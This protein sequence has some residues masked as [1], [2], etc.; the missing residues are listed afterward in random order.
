M[1]HRRSIKKGLKRLLQ[2]AFILTPL[3][4][5]GQNNIATGTWRTHYSYNNVISITESEAN[6][7]A[8]SNAGVFII[9]KEDNS[10]TSLTKLNGLSDS[11]IAQIGY[12]STTNTLVIAYKNG[13]LDLLNTNTVTSIPDIRLSN[14]LDIKVTHHIFSS[15]D[16]SYLSTD[17][18]LV[19]LDTKKLTIKESFLNLS[20]EG[21]PLKI[22]ASV[23]ANDSIFLATESGIMAGSLT[24]NL[25]D[26]T[27]WQ[28]FDATSGI[29]IEPIYALSLLN[30][31][32]IVGSTSMGISIY[33]NGTWMPSGDLIGEKFLYMDKTDAGTII[34]TSTGV[35][36]RTVSGLS[37]IQP[38]HLTSPT[39]AIKKSDTVWVADQQN[40]VLKVNVSSSES[41]Y[42]NGPFFSVAKKII[43]T[44]NKVFALHEF[45]TST[46]A[47]LRNNQGFS[48]FEDGF[49]TNYNAT[50]YPN[51][52]TTPEFMDISS[53]HA[54]QNNL[55]FSSYGYGL[56]VWESDGTFSI[57]D[58]SN[59]TL[60]NSFPPDRNVFVADLTSN[61][62][63][64]WVLNNNTSFPIQ[65]WQTGQNWISYS[66]SNLVADAQKIISTPWGDLWMALS[67]TAGG[68]LHV[69]NPQE[70][71]LT[72]NNNGN[73]TIP[74][75]TINDM[76]LDKEDKLWIATTKG[77]VYYARPYSILDEPGQEVVIPIIDF[78]PL[79]FQ[80]N[81]NAL[82]VDGG[83]RI[84]MGTNKGAWLFDKDGSE[85]IEHFTTENSPLLSDIVLNIAINDQ[86]GEV[87]FNTN[88]GLISFR[89]SGTITGTYTKPKIFPNPVHPGFSG[90]IT[91]EGVPYDC[92]LKITDASGRLVANLEANGNTAVWN[93]KSEYLSEIST[94][95][96]FVFAS[97]SDGTEKQLGKVAIVK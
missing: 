34:T 58:E 95:V 22:N 15:G 92:I 67:T 24:D 2:I 93:M 13:Q 87:F 88:E 53:V 23:I 4:G 19:Q 26:F 28:R 30:G 9:S 69:F 25:K 77:V 71:E 5:V 78:S 31:K 32:P 48:V 84:W 60:I 54:F 36:E 57:I 21:K 83:N 46:G 81:V 47:P 68:G 17:F 1:F 89:G 96:Y 73:G 8:A 14:I 66:A 18:G 52:E 51:T 74:S 80:E 44:G 42:P 10:I 6:L 45:K 63:G 72:L 39:Q 91:I 12:N 94:G 40:G 65:L 29:N 37:A 76:L 85:L 35:Y 38:E 3:W 33:S 16:F 79:F 11:G 49:W 7:Y 55:V 20:K 61:N 97:L 90:V 50:G 86:T 56:L 27:Q 70:G 59:S 43:S 64:L 75:N 82:A 41:I 62:Q